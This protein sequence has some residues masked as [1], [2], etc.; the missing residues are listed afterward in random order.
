MTKLSGDALRA[1]AMI[2]DE[3]GEDVLKEIYKEPK[4]RIYANKLNEHHLAL[5]KNLYFHSNNN[6]EFGA[7]EVDGKRPY[8]NSDVIDD[9][10]EITGLPNSADTLSKLH[11]SLH[12]VVSCIANH[13]DKAPQDLIGTDLTEYG[14]IDKDNEYLFKKE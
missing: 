5:L 10:R 3:F 14:L 9:I 4:P 8:G 13:P 7:F 2:E 12:A 6:C 1:I 11:F